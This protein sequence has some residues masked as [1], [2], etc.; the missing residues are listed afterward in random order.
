ML[1]QVLVPLDGSA[2]SEQAINY[3]TNVIA[4]GGKVILLSVIEVPTDYEYALVDVPMTLV[5]ARQFSEAEYN[6][7]YKRVQDYLAGFSRKLTAKGFTVETI[8]ETGEPATVINDTANK[9]KVEAIVMTT[10]G[11]TGLN[12]WLFGSVTQKVIS[13]MTRPVLVVPGTVPEKV[14]VPIGDGQEAPVTNS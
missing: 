2:L 14:Q 8:I 7:A 4:P 13:H 11:R 10:H 9:H 6:T 3:A 1:K 12:R 5:T